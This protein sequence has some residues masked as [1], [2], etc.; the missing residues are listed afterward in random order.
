MRLA[1]A[2]LLAASLAL[3]ASAADNSFDVAT[4]RSFETVM[5]VAK[6]RHAA[7]RM[8]AYRVFECTLAESKKIAGRTA[9]ER[10][11]QSLDNEADEA[12]SACRPQLAALV[13]DAPAGE[14][15]AIIKAVRRASAV[16]INIARSPRPA[17]C[18]RPEDA[19]CLIRYLAEP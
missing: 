10:G 3:P 4:M 7:H 9:G 6:M 5:S 11:K 17:E 14:A 8:S 12:M 15:A 19:Y 2:A 18:A 13:G 16:I 1:P